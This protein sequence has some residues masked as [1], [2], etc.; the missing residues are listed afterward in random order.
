MISSIGSKTIISNYR[1]S[2]HAQKK[3]AGRRKV[4]KRRKAVS[5]ANCIKL[6]T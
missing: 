4:G 2:I 1:I 3:L 5:E 6:D